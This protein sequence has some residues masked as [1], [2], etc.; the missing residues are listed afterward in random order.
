MAD[1]PMQCTQHWQASRRCFNDRPTDRTLQ[2]INQS[3][4]NQ[5]IPRAPSAPCHEWGFIGRGGGSLWGIIPHLN[6]QAAVTP[7]SGSFVSNCPP[8]SLGVAFF[9]F[10]GGLCYQEPPIQ[11][12]VAS[13]R[14]LSM[15]QTFNGPP[16]PGT[17]GRCEL[18]H[19]LCLQLQCVVNCGS[20]AGL[21][22]K[23]CAISRTLSVPSFQ[24]EFH[25]PN[26]AIRR[27]SANTLSCN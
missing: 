12:L 11:S 15:R 13:C 22:R 8:C 1:Q 4:I 17:N 6:I 23:T 7:R 5:A 16:K 20:P 21:R 27:P 26:P 14:H 19:R 18:Q 24:M 3:S 10:W 2:S 9:G 25:I